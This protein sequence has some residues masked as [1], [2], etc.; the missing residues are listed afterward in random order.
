MALEAA[1]ERAAAAAR[2]A[3]DGGSAADGGSDLPF[4]VPGGSTSP[5][6]SGSR[7]PDGTD[8]S[9]SRPSADE[10]ASP[11]RADASSSVLL[12]QVLGAADLMGY[13][14]LAVPP[15]P[16]DAI[17]PEAPLRAAILAW[18]A[19]T[20]SVVPPAELAAQLARADALPLDVQRDV[21][22][23]LLSTITA[24]QM[25]REALALLTPDELAWVYSHPD[26]ASDL[27]QGIS[28]PETRRMAILA[29]LVDMRK[30]IEATLLVLEAVEATRGSL[31]D[32]AARAELEGLDTASLDET[33]K[34]ILSL[35][36]ASDDKASDAQKVLLAA[37]LVSLAANVPLADAGVAPSFEDAL[38]ALLA[39]SGQAPSPAA[40]ADVLARAHAL[41]LDLQA[42]IARLVMAEAQAITAAS[43]SG[44][45]PTSQSAALANVLVATSAALPT[46]EKYGLYWRAA[47]DALRVGEWTPGARVGWAAHH[48]ALLASTHGALVDAVRAGDIITGTDPAVPKLKVLSF[49]D[50]YVDML[51]LAG[52]TVLPEHRAAADEGAARLDP[53]TRDA[54]AVLMSGAAQSARLQQQAFAHLSASEIETLRRA[55]GFDALYGEDLTAAEL[56]ELALAT[57]LAARVDEDALA[58][59]GIVATLA[60]EQARAILQGAGAYASA[61]AS[62]TPVETGV[63]SFLRHLLP[64][65]GARAQIDDGDTPACQIVPGIVDQCGEDVLLRLRWPVDSFGFT[66]AESNAAGQMPSYADDAHSGGVYTCTD[67]QCMV[68]GYQDPGD[69]HDGIRHYPTGGEA[70]L[71]LLVITGADSTT[72]TPEEAR[73]LVCPVNQIAAQPPQPSTGPTIGGGGFSTGSSGSV[74]AHVEP[75]RASATCHYETVM[76]Y[77]A[78]TVSLDL[79]GND[80]YNMPVAMVHTNAS[81]PVSLHLDMGGADRY[82]DPT[83]FYDIFSPLE[84]ALGSARGHPSQASAP[85]GGVAVLVDADGGDSY[86]APSMSQGYSRLGLAL[87]ADL[88]GSRD[89]YHA[90][91]LSQG[92][93]SDTFTLG[94]GILLDDGADDQY[95][96]MSGQGYGLGGVF[97]DLGGKDAYENEHAP[98]GAPL[99]NLEIVPGG[100]L[101]TLTERA[102]NRV[103][104]DGPGA[105]SAGLGVDTEVVVSN[106]DPDRDAFPDFVELLA[107]T[108]P[109]DQRSSPL[110]QPT[111]RAEAIANDT[112]GDGYPNYVERALSTDPDAPTSY[113][114]GFPSGPAIVI[115]QAVWTVIEENGLDGAGVG[116]R[117]D[118]LASNPADENDTSMRGSDKIVDLRLP[119]QDAG[120]ID[121]ACTGEFMVNG[122]APLGFFPGERVVGDQ[123]PI[124]GQTDPNTT[125]PARPQERTIERCAYVAYDTAAPGEGT[126][127]VPGAGTLQNGGDF[128]ESRFSF[129][130]PAGILAIGDVVETTYQ[131]DYFVIIDLGGRDH[132]VNSAGGALP[133]VTRSIPDEKGNF[134]PQLNDTFLAPS[135]VVNV[136]LTSATGSALAAGASDADEYVNAS[137]SYAQGSLYGVLVDTAG[138]DAYVAGAGSQGALGGALID[139]AGTDSYA[140]GDLSQ[141]ANLAG[142]PD[143]RE[144]AGFPQGG[145]V[146]NDATS[147]TPLGSARRD[148]GLLLDLGA[149][150]DTFVAGNHSQGFGR[151]FASAM[152]R[153]SGADTPKNAPYA[154][155]LL[156]STEGNETYAARPSATQTHGVGGIG[157][158]GALLDVKGRDR[159]FANDK[160]SFGWTLSQTVA[161]RDVAP[162]NAPRPAAAILV[163]LSGSDVYLQPGSVSL[164]RNQNTTLTRA[165]TATNGQT[166]PRLYADVGVHIDTETNDPTGAFL[167]GLV[168]GGSAIDHAGFLV[169]MPTARLAIGDSGH[170][171]FSDEYAFVVDLGGNNSYDYSA[172][173]LIRD[174]LAQGPPQNGAAAAGTQTPFS[175]VSQ[176]LNLFPVTFLLDAGTGASTYDVAHGLSQGVGYFGIGVLA[177]LGGRDEYRALEQAIPS[178]GSQWLDRSRDAIAIDGAIGPEWDFFGEPI[179]IELGSQRDARYTSDWTLRIANDNRSLYLALEGTTLSQT[180]KDRARDMLF[181]DLDIGHFGRQYDTAAGHSGIDELQ[182][183]YQGEDHACVFTDLG[184]PKAGLTTMQLDGLDASLTPR[185]VDV[186]CHA[187][188]DGHVVYEIRKDLIQTEIP[189]SIYDLAYCWADSV[190][191]GYVG[192]S[193]CEYP[194]DELGLYIGFADAGASYAQT[195]TSSLENFTFPVGAANRDGNYTGIRNSDI[196]DEMARW[197]GIGLATGLP[198][199]YDG[200]APVT[201]L[202]PSLAQGAGFAGVGVL[203]MLGNG[204]SESKLVA[205]DRAQGYAT[206]GGLGMLLDAGGSDEYVGTHAVQ[207]AAESF[208]AAIFID[209]EGN[210]IYDADNE[211]YGWVP[212]A[213]AAG[214]NSFGGATAFFLD[215]G[216]DD[217]YVSHFAPRA[218]ADGAPGFIEQGRGVNQP[219]GH[220]A[221]AFGNNVAWTQNGTGLGADYVLASTIR[222]VTAGALAQ[223]LYGTTRTTLN[224]TRYVDGLGCTSEII[225]PRGRSFFATG[226]VCFLATVNTSTGA[227]NRT[228]AP[229]TKQ[230]ATL[231]GGDPTD[232]SADVE[233][234]TRSLDVRSVDFFLDRE[235]VATSTNVTSVQ[236]GVTLWSAVVDLGNFSDGVKLA[237]ALPT[238]SAQL[239]DRSVLLFGD[240]MGNSANET[241]TRNATRTLVVNNAP[242]VKRLELAPEYTGIANATF[243]P[244]AYGEAQQLYVNWSASFDAEEDPFE[245]ANGWRIP[246]WNRSFPCEGL[247]IDQDQ[248]QLCNALTFY[249]DNAANT[250]SDTNP[251][252]D[253]FG[254]PA[255]LKVETI[256]GEPFASR[257]EP[258]G[259]DL[260]VTSKQSVHV[261]L[262]NRTALITTAPLNTQILVGVKY[263]N[264]TNVKDAFG[265]D[266]YLASGTFT[267]S[268]SA[269]DGVPLPDVG[270]IASLFGPVR[271]LVIDSL[272][273]TAKQVDDNVHG[274]VIFNVVDSIAAPVCTQG[275]AD[276]CATYN[277]DIRSGQLKPCQASPQP[278]ANGPG[279]NL[280]AWLVWYPV[281]VLE[282]GGVF[283]P[284]T[285][286]GGQQALIPNQTLPTGPVHVCVD[287]N[288][289]LHDVASAFTDV[290]TPVTDGIPHLCGLI[291]CKDEGGEGGSGGAGDLDN[292]DF[293]DFYLD[294]NEPDATVQAAG[295]VSDGSTIV[296]PKDMRLTVT[297]GLVTDNA[298]PG[299]GDSISG[300]F[301]AAADA[302]NDTENPAT[303]DHLVPGIE[304]TRGT[305]VPVL[306]RTDVRENVTTVLRN[307]GNTNG[308]NLNSLVGGL[309]SLPG[310]FFFYKSGGHP[311]YQAR[312][313]FRTPATPSTQVSVTLDDP[314]TGEVKETLR[315]TSYVEGDVDGSPRRGGGELDT[316]YWNA[317][318]HR[319]LANWSASGSSDRWTQHNTTRND[320]TREGVFL[321]NVTA[322]DAQGLSTSRVDSVLIDRTPPASFLTTGSVTPGS[323]AT[324]YVG[325]GSLAGAGGVPVEWASVDLSAASGS[326][327]PAPGSG[328][329]QVYVFYRHGEEGDLAT[330]WSALGATGDPAPIVE[331]N[332]A[333]ALARAIPA[334]RTSRTVSSSGD[335][336]HLFLTVAVD[337]AHNVEGT[338]NEA[339]LLDAVRS[340]FYAKLSRGADVQHGYARLVVD[341]GQPVFSGLALTGGLLSSFQGSDYTFVRAGQ[342]IAFGICVRDLETGIGTVTLQ[343]YHIDPTTQESTKASRAAT[344]AGACPAGQEGTMWSFGGWSRE[345]VD[346]SVFPEGIW[347]A[348]FDVE[349]KA[350]N[351]I[352]VSAGRVILDH[353]SPA[354]HVL[355]PILPPGQTAVKPGDQVKLRLTAEDAFGVDEG[356][357]TVDASAFAKNAS[358]LKVRP[359]RV[360][361]LIYQEATFFVDKPNLADAAY[362]I[363]VRV[364]DLAGNVTTVLVPLAV[365]AKAFDFVPGSFRVTNVTHNSLVL[366]WKTS[367]PTSAMAK[368]GTSAI[369]LNGRTPLDT[370]ASVEHALKVEGLQ[371]S[372]RYSLRAVSASTGGF[373]KESDIVE[374]TTITALFLQPQLPARGDNV[375]GLVKVA[376]RGGLLDSA[377]FVS[378]T[379]EVRN[380]TTSAWTFV[381]TATRQGDSHELRWNSTR[382]LDGTTYELRLTAEAG[383][384]VASAVI[385]PFT[386][387][388]TPPAVIVSSPLLATNDTTPR[389]LAETS[390]ALSGFPSV[391]AALYVDGEL[392]TKNLTIDALPDARLRLSYDI[393][394]ALEAGMRTFELRI[395]DNAGNV[396]KET[397]K[398]AIDG[399]APVITVNPT[400]YAPGTGAAK[401]GGTVTLNLTVHDLS[402]V[403]IVTADT[404]ALSDVGSV[405]LVKIVN[406]DEWQGTFSVSSAEAAATKTVKVH[407]VDL[408]GNEKDIDVSIPVDNVAPTVGSTTISETKHTRVVVKVPANEPILVTG[409]ATAPASPAVTV[410]SIVAAPTV[411]LAFEGLLP[412][413]SYQYDLKVTDLAGN[414]VP[415]H[416]SFATL[417]DTKAPTTVGPLSVLDLLNGTLRLSWNAATDDVA[418]AAYRVYRSEDAVVFRMVAEVTGTRY[419]DAGLPYEKLYT[420]KVAALDYG[421]NEGPTDGVLRASATAVPRLTVGAATPTIG[422][423]STTFHYAVTYASPGGKAPA[424]VRVILDGVPQNMTLVSGDAK[425]G[426]AYTYETRLA[427]HKRDA[428]HTYAFEA[429]D[430][431]YTARFPEDGSVLRG[432]LVSGDAL[433]GGDASGLASF[434]QKVPLG[435]IAGL[436]L[437]LVAAVGIAAVLGRKKKEGSK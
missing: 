252:G 187:S 372:T 294:A 418:V 70:S 368:F 254:T 381:T 64:F 282:R 318:G 271:Q 44:L 404:S 306:N 65:G 267:K 192:A 82:N 166:N 430:G 81:L 179:P 115:P 31:A 61:S 393:P 411:D 103:W 299:P 71:E 281:Q 350:G 260:R 419:D 413:R 237:K 169:D 371:P 322:T 106:A 140:A 289:N 250:E 264:G 236:R 118:P 380:A 194:R 16:V 358:A 134:T 336:V 359:V 197:A 109:A 122:S 432:P 269:T 272:G 26:V 431:R 231:A 101:T 177:D 223:T 427:P 397:W 176:P 243:S 348:Q 25:Q 104:L 3:S 311:D 27:A 244:Y 6:S 246:A 329:S 376:F 241:V 123:N 433:A 276:T 340:A 77:G 363:T 304:E 175:A 173:G 150:D 226:K 46:L 309:G 14:D 370:N 327:V 156:A 365:N 402:G 290:V 234:A 227:E 35:I 37:K 218:A 135:L 355:P 321:A 132:L 155:G 163:D 328:V 142:I 143:D 213:Q 55:Q 28:T 199:R 428:P 255:K 157:G 423:V 422:T 296:V 198:A 388:N 426:A 268:R 69:V 40:Q 265:K 394:D 284:N 17:A 158:V 333:P 38:A 39:A 47:P 130:V 229:L 232:G 383:H 111:A 30:S 51:T 416:G 10:L 168:G 183:A 86:D 72:H 356:R 182:I 331:D 21:A 63:L 415:L 302:V 171:T 83:S 139:L 352:S 239:A 297:V 245:A 18:V 278:I 390:D 60:G 84:L 74:P 174:Y 401:Q 112:D 131:D 172:A 342:P 351:S 303:G 275:G 316:A 280:P 286:P 395:L 67:A 137:R 405:R 105:L 434:A 98:N 62:A 256:N 273:T 293:T 107:G 242:V 12:G 126:G 385:G 144:T 369:A 73:R 313:E 76:R 125:R 116:R 233:N 49:T 145:N 97:V 75:A 326:D 409:T 20:G 186:K 154:L 300:A 387:D 7:A 230:L 100:N 312:I 399:D 259:A 279:V 258:L 435:G 99:V 9:S 204:D 253:A 108:D 165:E 315:D 285:A 202:K 78:P 94:V 398:V 319:P 406:A 291:P 41:P 263:A 196:S 345:N 305:G 181:V 283:R 249:L 211:S 149:G 170:T 147:D 344:P 212:R 220:M 190:G 136:D 357:I 374:A 59:A 324:V 208:S 274:N 189:P 235:R 153:G 421:A 354:V 217:R 193:G 346:K 414:E 48:A 5:P 188:E 216:G 238:F 23:L 95:A 159:Y 195:A 347:L 209:V 420:Y 180:E 310:S 214:G 379:L 56:E 58:Q 298:Q 225:E 15:L 251:G 184:A 308:Q 43:P 52:Y 221:P 288:G 373:S 117:V 261:A 133:V 210:D 412:S 410:S 92:A 102:D 161:T 151:G 191:F 353:A 325:S 317:I 400:R 408:A 124:F 377:D 323:T 219:S 19:A 119:L 160:W 138:A 248:P 205:A 185:A 287:V 424:Y 436:A 417:Q 314:A 320:L 207:G 120:S 403:S 200:V 53:A 85:V 292:V 164:A 152:N 378:Y 206:Y 87:L 80:V 339:T 88:S 50:A 382:F 121:Y 334:T 167:A 178:F 364:P 240:E 270:G 90:Q 91:Q 54:A 429:S 128:S 57:A 343:L 341:Q 24:T 301:N 266:W 162:A 360:N 262:P 42:A 89:I 113:P 407:A 247:A 79:D 349:D 127:S 330:G 8:G 332:F 392:V 389:L 148:V 34:A 110:T 45:T 295:I 307:F 2:H 228:L 22:L 375:S 201:A 11:V 29:S 1:D 114:A 425:T 36:V 337:R 396:A 32:H 277:G 66:P 68:Y 391:P 257:I 215:L 222:D 96:A 4:V 386:S 361:G 367:E 203:A 338:A 33:T 335:P 366:H 362:T 129:Q 93:A 146:T 437:A 384:D 141:G 13:R 224:F